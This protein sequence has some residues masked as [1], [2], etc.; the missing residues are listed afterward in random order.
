ML[1]VLRGVP[2]STIAF[3]HTQGNLE[4]QE[5]KGHLAAVIRAAGW[6]VDEGGSFVFFGDRKG[7]VVTIPFAASESGLPQ[8]VA[9][10]LAQ[11][12]NA[13]SGNRGDMANAHG[14]YVEVW[15]AP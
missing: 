9:H 10:A 2:P 6:Q 15:H 8:V 4:A 1:G 3:A 12:G 13:V 14:L 5:F 11:T 7:L